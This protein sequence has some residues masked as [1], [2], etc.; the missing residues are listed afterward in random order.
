[1]IE[2]L[3]LK[4]LKEKL[5]VPVYLERPDLRDENFVFFEK[6]GSSRENFL[7]SS[8]FAFQSYGRSLYEAAELNN[9]LKLAMYQL[10]ELSAVSK[11]KLNSDYN[12][13]DIETKK[14]R[15]QA[16]FDIWHY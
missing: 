12:F 1:M 4:F 11:I 10:I 7:E 16:V 6:T 13:T 2:L 14:P 9:K 5:D 8:T 15:Y 3:I